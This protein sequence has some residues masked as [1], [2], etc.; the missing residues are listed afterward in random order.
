MGYLTAD[1]GYYETGLRFL[2]FGGRARSKQR[3]YHFGRDEVDH[4]ASKTGES[5]KLVVEQNGRGIY[6]YQARD[7]QATETDSHLGTRVHLHATAVGKVML[8]H[9]S[10]E[11]RAEVIDRHGLPAKTENTTTDRDRLD[12]ELD[13]VR[14][15]GVAFDDEERMQGIRCVASPIRTAGV[16]LAAISVSGPTTEIDSTAFKKTLPDMV[17][18][19]TRVVEMD[20][21]YAP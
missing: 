17:R 11:R 8:A 19:A 16:R 3:L 12:N 13:T 18:N 1:D 21:T 15:R 6:L 14:E 5:A 4:L 10:E 7:E 2:E 20:V 9:M